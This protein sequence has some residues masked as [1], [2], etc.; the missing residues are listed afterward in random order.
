MLPGDRTRYSAIVGIGGLRPG[1]IAAN[2]EIRRGSD[3]TQRV[4]AAA[5]SED[6]LAYAGLPAAAVDVLI[7]ASTCQRRRAQPL[8]SEIAGLLGGTAMA[9]DV[10]AAAAGFCCALAAASDMVAVGKAQCVA[11]VGTEPD[12]A[13][14]VVVAAVGQPGI[15]KA[16]WGSDP[17]MAGAPDERRMAAVIPF[18]A[19]Q[20]L[21]AAG[22]T[23]DDLAAFIPQQASPRISNSLAGAL[24]LPAHV[25][26]AR[27]VPNTGDAGTAS[28]P[29]AM[30]RMRASG[31]VSSGGYALLA[32][33]GA[34]ASYAAQ[35]TRLP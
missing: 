1:R 25:R 8:A 20:A 2:G 14:A 11:V 15:G 35:V 3:S 7:A 19:R 13:G 26:V 28:I 4:M 30:A 33:F 22:L 24:A 29:L 9:F 12:G 23:V 21:A 16:A 5:A 27:D 34:G 10:S 18:V 6:A 31:E 17:T 32:G